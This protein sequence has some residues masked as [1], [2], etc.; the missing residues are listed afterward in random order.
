MS[1]LVKKPNL[2]S[3]LEKPRIQQVFL[4]TDMRCNHVGLSL[5]AKRYGIDTAALPINN[6]LVF[7]NRRQT[8][9]KV[10][11]HGNII[12]HTKRNRIS[13][14]AIK[15]IPKVFGYKGVIDYDAALG[16]ALEKQLA[17]RVG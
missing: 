10:Y 5:L 9:L 2:K 4:E 12:A 1:T 13:L 3:E 16:I 8:H 14:D 15:E 7:I 11:V 6:M 17:K